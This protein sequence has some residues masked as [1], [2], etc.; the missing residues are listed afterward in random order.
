MGN[1]CS[2]FRR[3]QLVTQVSAY[4]WLV[5]CTVTI[6]AS[7]YIEGNG[8][9]CGAF[10]GQDTLSTH[11]DSSSLELCLRGFTLPMKRDIQIDLSCLPV[12]IVDSTYQVSVVGVWGAELCSVPL[13]V[14]QN[15]LTLDDYFVDWIYHHQDGFNPAVVFEGIGTYSIVF[16][17]G[18]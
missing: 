18:K 12:E 1:L 15:L 2:A 17:F 16:N 10:Q 11:V 14:K 5:I 3:N 8:T 4:F 7:P 6:G 13:V 9:I